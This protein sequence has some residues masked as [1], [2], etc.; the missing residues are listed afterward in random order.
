MTLETRVAADELVGRTLGHHLV[1]ELLG[2]GGMG[3]VYKARDTRLGRLVALK[4]MRHEWLEDVGTQRRLEREAQAASAL[5]HPNI[6]TIYEIGSEGP[7]TYIAMEYITGGTLAEGLRSGPFP[8]DH[9]LRLAAQVADALETAHAAGIVHRDLKPSNLMLA[10]E[11]RVKVVDFGIAKLARSAA[12]AG[13]GPTALTTSGAIVGSAPYMSPEQAAGRAVDE[14]SDIFSL[15][16]VL[17]EMLAGRRP[18][19]GADGAET[20]AA[21]LRDPPPPIPG[22]AP[23]IARLLERSLAKDPFE[24]FQSAA[25]LKAAIEACLSEP[26][27]A[28]GASVAV[29]P[30]ANMSGTKEDDF[31]CEGLAEEIIN[32]LTR[33]P[34][35]R[36]IART[37]SFAVARQGLD[38]RETASRLGVESILEGSVRRAGT[39]VRVTAQLVSARDGS[40]LW[41]ERYDRE[42]TDLLVLEDDV[43]AAIADKL[44]GGLAREAGARRHREVDHEAYVAFLEGRHYFARGTPE[45]LTKAMVCYQRAIERDPGFALAYDSLAELHWFLGFFGNVPPRDAFSAGTWH[46]LRALELD[47]TL[48]ETHALLGMLRKELDY[49]WVEVERECRRGLDLS[50]ESPLV[51]LR[52]AISGLMPH[53]RVVEAMAEL[54]AVVRVDPLSIPARWW[55][56]VM[57]AFAR[58]WDRVREE[59]NHIIA[60]DA[61]HFTG[62]WALGMQL[63]GIGAGEKAVAALQRAHEL[64]GGV[65]FTLGFLAYGCGRAGQADKA[66]ALLE[67]AAEA[68]KAGY[69]PPSTFAFGHIGLGEWD[70]AFEWLDRAVDGRDPL[71]MPIKTYVFLDPVRDDPRYH[72]LLRKMNL[73]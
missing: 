13:D 65:P 73:G 3:V 4:V 72:A 42:M 69:L 41:S 53:G 11:G 32:A 29:L 64:S 36:V 5:N 63:D 31:L 46:A 59:A 39:R 35:L 54:E 23:E 21:I 37:S 43:A 27:H 17:Y 16:A 33:I 40:H 28:E 58:D 1:L 2:E 6:L 48:A 56:A 55:L 14:R 49:N 25:E 30:F 18:F 12:P 47:D 20:L 67:G 7:I 8:S 60:L 50:P 52:Y 61:T 57:A 45:A 34:G 51:R 22:L 19:R 9:A 15:G 26:S 68:A 70:A 66:R 24:R 10:G 44:R 62:H 71:V 38:V